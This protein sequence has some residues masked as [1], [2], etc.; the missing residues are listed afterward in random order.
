MYAIRSYY[1]LW[2]QIYE[3]GQFVLA[4]VMLSLPVAYVVLN[5]WIGGFAYGSVLPVW[6]MISSGFVIILLSLLNIIPQKIILVKSDVVI[7]EV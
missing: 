4:G 3:V 7:G 6:L 1:V 5:L 2:E